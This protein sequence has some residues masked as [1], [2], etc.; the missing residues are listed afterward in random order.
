MHDG[1]ARNYQIFVPSN[2]DPLTPV[3]LVLNY[4]GLGSDAFEQRYYSLFDAVAED[5][6]F[7]VVYPNG[8]SKAWNS[9]IVAQSTADDVGFTE[10]LIDKVST[11][12]S[13]NPRRIYA[14]G[15]SNGG[16]MVYRLACELEH[17]ITAIASVTGVIA[18]TH[19]NNCQN[20]R[21]VPVMQ[22]HGTTDPIVD[23]NGLPGFFLGA[24]ASVDFWVNRNNCD[25]SGVTTSVLDINVLDLCTAERTVYSSCDNATEAILYKITNGGHTWPD[26][27]VN[28]PTNG[29]T[30]R[31]FNATREIWDFFS[32]HTL[33]LGTNSEDINT[34]LP[35]SIAPNP[36]D[37]QLQIDVAHN[38]SLQIVLT[39]V[40]GH[41]V[42]SQE[43]ADSS[44]L[45][46]LS[47]LTA[48]IYFVTLSSG[49]SQITKKIVK[50]NN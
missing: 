21:P 22:I 42:L 18:P 50:Q 17:K 9:G 4:H 36:F 34:F 11:D 20:N 14:T 46:D 41:T 49:D 29:N 45:L 24:E 27:S 33:P 10:A 43:T 5:S 40:L 12:Y 2:Y 7:I 26:A 39:N 23:Y 15:M 3:P 1:I 47:D 25:P 13:I 37:D 38:K 19:V 35:H 28:I 16:I 8:I 32:R 48:G 44:V 30:N 6:T 31:D